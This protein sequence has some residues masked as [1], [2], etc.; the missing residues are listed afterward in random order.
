MRITFF[1]PPGSGK[2]TQ[3]DRISS[4]FDLQHISTG[5]LFR[6]EIES[7]S[8]LGNRIR[9]IVESGNLVSDEIANEEVF[10][11]IESIDEFLLDGYPRNLSQAKCLDEFLLNTGRP[12]SG[13]VSIHIPDEEVIRRLT[14]RLVCAC[15]NGNGSKNSALSKEG[16]IC[17]ICGQPFVKRSDDILQVMK[18]RLDH[19]YNLTRHLETY[20]E[21]RILK[22][23]GSGTIDQVFERIRKELLA[24]V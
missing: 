5:M 20:Y 6:E 1:G 8:E 13:A 15:S 11:R 16:D 23:D 22:I 12:L 19:Y 14:G 17:P 4:C 9:E 21:N 18:N 10:S 3:A 2:G 7:G 24:W